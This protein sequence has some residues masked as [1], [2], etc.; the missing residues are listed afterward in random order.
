M[1]IDCG[2][3]S[4]TPISLSL[5][6]S[7][8]PSGRPV[9]VSGIRKISSHALLLR[10]RNPRVP[11]GRPRPTFSVESYSKQERP[12]ADSQPGRKTKSHRHKHKRKKKEKKTEK[13]TNGGKNYN[14]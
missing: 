1:G 2:P 7:V 5:S 3:Q 6:L 8:S 14:T 11:H 4:L 12:A 13:K 10:P 9:L